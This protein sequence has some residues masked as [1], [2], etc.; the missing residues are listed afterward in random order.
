[1]NRPRRNLHRLV[2]YIMLLAIPVL[3]AI[4]GREFTKQLA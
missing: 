3:I 1:M 2:W 4:A